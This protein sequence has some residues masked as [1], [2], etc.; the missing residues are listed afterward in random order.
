MVDRPSCVNCGRICYAKN[1]SLRST[2]FRSISNKKTH[3]WLHA[4]LNARGI[5]L[6]PEMFICGPCRTIFRKEQRHRRSSRYQSTTYTDTNDYGDVSE[7]QQLL[8]VQA[9]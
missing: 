3:R 4:L 5:Q 7:I 1:R 9:I 2:S 6:Q 8:S